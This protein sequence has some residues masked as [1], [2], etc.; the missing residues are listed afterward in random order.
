M[1]DDMI[2]EVCTEITLL[3]A[4]ASQIEHTKVGNL[5]GDKALLLSGL[6]LLSTH[7]QK[8]KG[9]GLGELT[10]SGVTGP[11]FDDEPPASDC[12]TEGAHKWVFETL[13]DLTIYTRTHDLHGLADS[14]ESI[15]GRN[16]QNLKATEPLINR[17]GIGNIIA[18]APSRRCK[19]GGE[20]S[21]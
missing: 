13:Q 3:S 4:Y 9:S 18:F 16:H 14:L 20:R 21:Q 2:A 19:P 1:I 5:Q 17:N 10:E 6:F 8:I 11:S 12:S 7:A 15:C